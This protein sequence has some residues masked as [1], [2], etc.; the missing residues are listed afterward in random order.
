MMAIADM[1]DTARG[2]LAAILACY[3]KIMP[4]AVSS[5]LEIE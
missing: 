1:S 2:L 3:P 4:V 5:L